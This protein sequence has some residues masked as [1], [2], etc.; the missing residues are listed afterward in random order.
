LGLIIL[1]GHIYLSDLWLAVDSRLGLVKNTCLEEIGLGV[2]NL[3]THRDLI[4]YQYMRLGHDVFAL[5]PTM[6]HL[7]TFWMK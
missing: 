6:L 1:N 7:Q 5:V 2:W 3:L 4:S